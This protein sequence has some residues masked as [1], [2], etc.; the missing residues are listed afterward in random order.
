MRRG[1]VFLAVAFAVTAGELR[2]QR[3][4]VRSRN[5][6]R[7]REHRRSIYERPLFSPWVGGDADFGYL[8]ASCPAYCQPEFDPA[9]TGTLAVGMTFKSRFTLSAER[10]WLSASFSD[11]HNTARLSMLTARAATWS[12]FAATA[13]F[14]QARYT[15]GSSALV[16]DKPAWKIGAEKCELG[17]V[18]G[19]LTLHYA[20]TGKDP[21]GYRMHVTQLGYALRFHL[22]PGHRITLR[23][24]DP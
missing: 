14:G 2:A 3:I 13:G 9:F 1:I 4:P 10:S 12:G 24:R 7:T 17:R 21:A 11:E 22:R 8:V 18:D 15:R 5:P 20:Q 19:C 23:P 16:D 6:P